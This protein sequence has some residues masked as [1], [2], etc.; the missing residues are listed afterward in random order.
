MD[1]ALDGN[2]PRA[3]D[4]GTAARYRGSAQAGRGDRRRDVEGRPGPAAGLSTEWG[5]AGA[6]NCP[7]ERT[8]TA[9]MAVSRGDE[10]D[11][12]LIATPTRAHRDLLLT[13]P[14]AGKALLCGKPVAPTFDVV[15]EM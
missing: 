9:P 1:G 15:T 13:R 11:A 8:G 2:A 7:F 3:H 6:R 12:V 5:A 14:A 10:V 4:R